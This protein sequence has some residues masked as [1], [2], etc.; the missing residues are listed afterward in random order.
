MR[1]AR[2]KVKDE[3]CYYHLMSRV[4]G[5]PGDYP[6]GDVEK[7]QAFKI[8]EDL[9]KL[10]FLEVIS[11]CCMEINWGQALYYSKLHDFSE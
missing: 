5:C 4:S 2:Q 3:G 8:L 6:F 1:K 7:E 10:Y 11:F 9:A